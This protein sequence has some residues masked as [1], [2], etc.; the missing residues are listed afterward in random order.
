ME[1]Y[2]HITDVSLYL[3]FILLSTQYEFILD[4]YFILWIY[5]INKYSIYKL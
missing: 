5:T 4:L 3:T 2:T 1:N